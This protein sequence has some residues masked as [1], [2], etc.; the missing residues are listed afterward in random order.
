VDEANCKTRNFMTWYFSS[1]I[2]ALTKSR[3]MRREGH[4]AWMG[5]G[6]GH[7]RCGL[8]GLREG[9][10]LEDLGLDGKIILKWIF[11]K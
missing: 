1:N 3:R 11:K 10:K 9:D 2:I 8:G 7:T 4:V 6:Q 5:R